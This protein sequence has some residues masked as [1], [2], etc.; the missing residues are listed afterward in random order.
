M[1]QFL[2]VDIEA[3]V[4]LVITLLLVT[5]A[6]V[7]AIHKHGPEFVKKFCAGGQDEL[8]DL[9]KVLACEKKTMVSRATTDVMTLNSSQ[10]ARSKG[11]PV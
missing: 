8:D 6:S 9:V 2:S 10:S 3:M 5:L 7:N 4:R 11:D 1:S